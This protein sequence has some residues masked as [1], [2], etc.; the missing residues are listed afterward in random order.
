MAK[1]QG[2]YG[3][4]VTILYVQLRPLGDSN[5]R[6]R[7]Y[8]E[9]CLRNQTGFGIVGH[10]PPSSFGLSFSTQVR[11]RTHTDQAQREGHLHPC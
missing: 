6:A 8:E 1:G 7:E 3:A 5:E 9:D 2:N 4:G 11:V 10:L